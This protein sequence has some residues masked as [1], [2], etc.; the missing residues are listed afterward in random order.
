MQPIRLIAGFLTVGI[1]T[2]LSRVLGFVRD[3]L[4]AAYLG[5]SAGEAQAESWLLRGRL[6]K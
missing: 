1:W 2:L 4:I 5:D 6:A 3:I